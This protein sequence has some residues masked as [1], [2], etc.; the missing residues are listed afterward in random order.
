MIKEYRLTRKLT[1]Q[2]LADMVGFSQATI[3]KH[4][5]EDN[6]ECATCH[7]IRQEIYRM[8]ENEH[9]LETYR[10]TQEILP[11]RN[12]LIPAPKKSLFRRW[13]HAIKHFLWR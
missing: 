10:K 8:I 13:A 6:P 11:I 2:Q 9:R 7:I 3:S 12:V 4:E 5:R 1:Q